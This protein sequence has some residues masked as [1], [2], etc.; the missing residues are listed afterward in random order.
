MEGGARPA[1]REAQ[2]L[3]VRP[4]QATA[5]AS[6][7]LAL[8]VVSGHRTKR[9]RA[10]GNSITY[11]HQRTPTISNSKKGRREDNRHRDSRAP[12]PC[13]TCTWPEES[14]AVSDFLNDAGVQPL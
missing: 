6:S 1:M 11:K 14:T 10:Y 3:R 8:Q 4:R 13:T 2:E 5:G 7:Y 12:Q 9:N